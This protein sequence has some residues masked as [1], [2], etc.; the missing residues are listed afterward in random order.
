ML[1]LHGGRRLILESDGQ[2]DLYPDNTPSRFK[3]RLPEPWLLDDTWEVALLQLKLPHTWNNVRVNQIAF[4][5]REPDG[6]GGQKTSALHLPP[7][8]YVTVQ[9]VV[10]QLIKTV[11]AHS[12]Q[13]VSATLNEKSGYYGWTL[14]TDCSLVVSAQV[15]RLLGYLDFFSLRIPFYLKDNVHISQSDPTTHRPVKVSVTGDHTMPTR[16]DHNMWAFVSPYSFQ[17]VYMHCNLSRPVYMGSQMAK[18]L[19]VYGVDTKK[20]AVENISSPNP[21]FYPLSVFD[22]QEIEIDIR[23]NL[24]R[25]IPFERGTVTATLY[26]R[27]RALPT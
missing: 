14:P 1:R 7:G 12:S 3:A 19:L 10:E 24:D 20:D 8:Q 9:D 13:T 18:I 6:S 4:E 21:T 16:Y 15:A 25:P 2:L 17:N 23:D 11:K 26:F 22:F 27:R 5:F